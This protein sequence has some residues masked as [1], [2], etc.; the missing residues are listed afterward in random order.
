MSGGRRPPERTKR[1]PAQSKPTE[2]KQPTYQTRLP[3]A[4]TYK[5]IEAWMASERQHPQTITDVRKEGDVFVVSG[6]PKGEGVKGG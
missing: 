6:E 5:A 3:K 1:P 4:E 2:T